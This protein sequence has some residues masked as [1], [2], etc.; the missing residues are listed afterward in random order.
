MY[1][2]LKIKLKYKVNYKI[3]EL[4]KIFEHPMLIYYDKCSLCIIINLSF[5][6]GL[7]WLDKN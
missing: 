3:I 4:S 1:S 2:L 7:Y 5:G 6:Y